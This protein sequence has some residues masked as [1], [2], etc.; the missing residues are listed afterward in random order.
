M[1]VMV[2]FL[3]QEQLFTMMDEKARRDRN[4][5]AQ[6]LTELTEQEEEFVDAYEVCILYSKGKSQNIANPTVY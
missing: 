2:W 4:E 5:E 6:K 3:H 1:N